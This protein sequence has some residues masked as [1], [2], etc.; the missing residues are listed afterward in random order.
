MDC[1]WG[2]TYRGSHTGF[3]WYLRKCSQD[4]TERSLGCRKK[5]KNMAMFWRIHRWWWSWWWSYQFLRIVLFI[6]LVLLSVHKKY[7]SIMAFQNNPKSVQKTKP[8][9]KILKVKQQWGVYN[10][11]ISFKHWKRAGHSKLW[12]MLKVFHL[13]KTLGLSIPWFYQMI[14]FHA[15]QAETTAW[16]YFRRTTSIT[17]ST[18]TRWKKFSFFS[19]QVSLLSIVI[20]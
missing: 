13:F 20:S 5:A 17:M 9:S 4:W 6:S 18:N 1:F 14:S 7:T 8:A 19:F 11:K 16:I 12:L 3:L 10:K 2:R 15:M